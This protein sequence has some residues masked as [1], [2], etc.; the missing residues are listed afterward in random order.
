MFRQVRN[1][2]NLGFRQRTLIHI[3]R[4]QRILS[5]KRRKT[6]APHH[7]QSN[8][9]AENAVKSFKVGVTKALTDPKTSKI[10]LETTVNRYL[11]QYRSAS[12]ATTKAS[13]FKLM[14]GRDMR[15]RLDSIKPRKAAA[16]AKDVDSNGDNELKQ[17][18]FVPGETVMVRDYSVSGLRWQSATISHSTGTDMYVCD[19]KRGP[20]TRHANQILRVKHPQ[21]E[22]VNANQTDQVDFSFPPNRAGTKQAVNVA[23]PN[24][25]PGANDGIIDQ[26]QD[27]ETDDENFHEALD[28]GGE[29]HVEDEEVEEIC[30]P[31]HEQI[32][33]DGAN[34]EVRPAAISSRRTSR[35]GRRVRTPDRLTYRSK[36]AK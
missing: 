18:K 4:I 11:F 19:T 24:N 14:F 7:P 9:A 6:I 16:K 23:V 20:W 35:A 27:H 12:H 26:N 30:Q 36:P 32:P 8:G 2:R 22:L 3:S 10:P 17:K 31:P 29:E 25:A 5:E 15:T 1:T 33:T 28:I 21:K 34:L 13:P